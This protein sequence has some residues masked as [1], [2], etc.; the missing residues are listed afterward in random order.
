MPEWINKTLSGH[1]IKYYS[2]LRRAIPT[3]AT[4]RMKLEN[5]KRNRPDT[6]GQIL[7]DSTSL[8]YK[9]SQI[10]RQRQTGVAGAGER[11][12]WLAFNGCSGH[13]DDEK[14]WRW[15]LVMVSQCEDT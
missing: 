11:S 6:K 9:R 1:T 15:T 2:A 5:T 7:C 8:R 4:T 12:G 13:L 14:F 10:Q 3:H